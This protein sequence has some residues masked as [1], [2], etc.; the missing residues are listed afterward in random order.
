MKNKKHIENLAKLLLLIKEGN[1]YG[2]GLKDVETKI[3]SAIE[4][5]EN[6]LLNVVLFGSFSDGKTTVAAGWLEE[7]F[8]NMKI[9][10][11]ESSD[12]ICIYNSTLK[13]VRIID[14]PGLFGDK[15]KSVD[16]VVIKYEEQT[17]KYISEAHLILYVVEAV[18]PIKDSHKNII[19]WV[20]QDLGKLEQTIF[21]VNKMDDVANLEDEKDFIRNAEI[22]TKVIKDTIKSFLEI[23]EEKSEKLNIVCV[24]ADP[25][26]EG[27]K[28][29]FNN[30]K[31]YRELSRLEGLKTITSDIVQNNEERLISGVSKSVMK[32]VI[33]TKT[34][35]LNEIINIEKQ[36]IY[37]QKLELKRLSS[38]IGYLKT[39]AGT[40]VRQAKDN[41]G[42]LR[43]AIFYEIDGATRETYYSVIERN[44]GVKKNG[45]ELEIGFL[46]QQKVQGIIDEAIEGLQGRTQKITLDLEETVREINEGMQRMAASGL[47][48]LIKNASKIP[49]SKIRDGI[50]S[51]RNTLKLSTKFKP[52]GALKLAGNFAKGA[53]ILGALLD[54][55]ISYWEKKKAEK[56]NKEKME[57][58]QSIGSFF[59]DI[60]DDLGSTDDFINKYIPSFNTLQST[61]ED[62]ET[63]NVSFEEK[64]EKS[65]VWKDK[66]FNFFDA[67]EIPFEEI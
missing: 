41:L 6:N 29:W 64:L 47:S 17:K 18:N 42:N 48:E 22:K 19:K 23:S 39:D 20:L 24:S 2:L 52:W 12:E 46:L 38:D 49:V 13:N 11:N 33:T 55:G 35:E 62:L 27:L 32:D 15:Q 45:K 67:E 36:N 65:T 9:D 59:S 5:L 4:S 21:V 25:F 60:L 51:A 31:E 30:I 56:F 57:M 40:A 1:I 37:K 63:N 34:N 54:I 44:L 7:E 10:T 26:E 58:K 3:A 16:N 8:D 61:I 14:T 53:A 28:E 66:V 50:L 43:D